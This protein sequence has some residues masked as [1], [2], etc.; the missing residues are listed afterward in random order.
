MKQVAFKC[1][2]NAVNFF[3]F[4]DHSVFIIT[5]ITMVDNRRFHMRDLVLRLP[6]MVFALSCLYAHTESETSYTWKLDLEIG[7]VMPGA[8]LSALP[9]PAAPPS[10]SASSAEMTNGSQE[11]FSAEF[12]TEDQEL[13]LDILMSTVTSV[14]GTWKKTW[15]E[16]SR[17]CSPTSSGP[18]CSGMS[19]LAT[20]NRGLP[21]APVVAEVDEVLECGKPVN[22][23]YYDHLVGIQNR[24]R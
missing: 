23:T 19:T 11:S 21:I 2:R 12:S 5:S 4:E 22:F 3:E 17:R 10:S 20:N 18:G 13:M 24:D 14:D 15:K 8:Y 6:L 1:F 16:E 9:S 7:K